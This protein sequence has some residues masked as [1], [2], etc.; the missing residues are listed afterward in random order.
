MAHHPLAVLSSSDTPYCTE[1]SRACQQVTVETLCRGT[2]DA[3]RND[4]SLYSRLQCDD[5]VAGVVD[6]Q[7]LTEL[8]DRRCT[9]FL[10]DEGPW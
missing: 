5:E 6:A 9:R 3:T 8:N 2:K 10:D 7:V 1:F 4:E